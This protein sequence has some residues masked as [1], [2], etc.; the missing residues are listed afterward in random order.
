[1]RR[2]GIINQ[3]WDGVGEDGIVERMD[4]EKQ[5][6]V[7]NTVMEKVITG[8]GDLLTDKVNQMMNHGQEDDHRNIPHDVTR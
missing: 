1:M 5:I 4:T 3:T 7:S 6:S 8:V 2:G